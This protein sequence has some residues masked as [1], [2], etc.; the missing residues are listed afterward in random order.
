MHIKTKSFIGYTWIHETDKKER[1]I[2]YLVV[3]VQQIHSHAENSS[4]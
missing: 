4:C 2:F 3:K 1:Q